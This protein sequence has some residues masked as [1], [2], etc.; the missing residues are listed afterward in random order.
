VGTVST[1][2]ELA[3][4]LRQLRRRDAHRRRDAPHTYRQLAAR[5]GWSFTVISQ[6]FAGT[7]L[8]PTDRF[9]ELI[10]LLGATPAEQHALATARDRV[11][12]RRRGRPELGSMAYLP[13][14]LP[15]AARHFTG[16]RG[17]LAALDEAARAGAGGS[18][19]AMILVIDGTAGV[20]KTTLAVHWARSV[21]GKFPDGQLYVN[22]RG[23]DH[24]QPVPP[25]DAVRGLLEAYSVPGN[26]MP[27]GLDARAAL[28]RSLLAGRRVLVVLDN[29]A[30]AEQ[31]RPLLPGS[32]GCLAVVTSRSRLSGLVAAGARTITLGPLNRAEAGHLLAHHVGVDET[33]AEPMAVEDIA[34]LCAGLPL[35]LA[36]VAVRATTNGV[37]LGL[38]AGELH[39]TRGT[40]AAYQTD[41]P[42]LDVRT[43]LSWS[44]RRLDAA[45]ARLFRLLEVHPGPEIS[46]RAAASLTGR[47]A[48][49]TRL[50]L[51]ELVRDHLIEERAVGRYAC[52]DLLRA[53]ARER[54]E[55]VDPA[56][57]RRSALHRVLDHYVRSAA[58][59][60][61]L[62]DP[63]L[64]PL[65][66]AR[67]GAGVSPERPADT[68]AAL[69]WFEAER[70]VL[71]NA[72]ARAV[73]AGLDRQVW[74]LAGSL[75]TFLERRGR[76]HDWAGT[77]RAAVAAA[78]RSG[79]PLA[80]ADAHRCL[81]RASIRLDLAAEARRNLR[82]ALA[83]YV[84]AGHE[85]GQG[86]VQ[87]DLGETL[88]RQGRPADALDHARRAIDLF[89][90][91]GYPRG[92]ALAMNAIGC[93]HARLGD[94]IGALAW[95]Q[96]ALPL[97]EE[98]GDRQGAAG[99]WAGLGRAHHQLGQSARAVVCYERAV[100][101]LQRSGDR[102]QQATVLTDLGDA[103]DAAGEPGIALEEWSRAL[104]ILDEL[105]HPDVGPVLARLSRGIKP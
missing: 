92:R 69:A 48:G 18:G 56:D 67:P 95:S 40:L 19:P 76:W 89:H 64:D 21:S 70:A 78:I 102:Y 61:E 94:H 80:R 31:V 8:P 5:T 38:L 51:G 84:Q 9:D 26:R 85:V 42:N 28:Y 73:D 35:A 49:L 97:L 81:A 55:I 12:E 72:V 79:N 58:A 22:L 53:Y 34:D 91:A 96:R 82:R 36:A 11:E 39:R 62:L 104:A 14:Q 13:R 88:T 77:Q 103:H 101:L 6:Y 37:P 99:A 46:A 23:F 29:A 10:L 47:P 66:L 86:W 98:A 7:V 57:D 93:L 3:S 45:A 2:P 71:L 16:R 24:G 17:E 63:Y 20:G 75:S 33:A 59:A 52:H 50:L 1:M 25:A 32:P 54:S 87:L 74:Q 83:L 90:A 60:D 4:V 65:V 43:V 27:D 15:P 44:Y 68:D 100:G 105:A 41:D 30:T